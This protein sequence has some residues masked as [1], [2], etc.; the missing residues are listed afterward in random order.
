[1]TMIMHMIKKKEKL[2][3]SNKSQVNMNV[4]GNNRFV[5]K[6]PAITNQGATYA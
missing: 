5:C 3:I 6:F 4:A 1:M 2:K